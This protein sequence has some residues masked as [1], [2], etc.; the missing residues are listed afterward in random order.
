MT[1]QNHNEEGCS[2]ANL[3]PVFDVA[4]HWNDEVRKRIRWIPRGQTQVIQ[5]TKTHGGF[6]LQTPGAPQWSFAV[7]PTLPVGDPDRAHRVLLRPGQC[8][9]YAQF[10]PDQ[11]ALFL[12]CLSEN[13]ID[14]N[15]PV[16][17]CARLLAATYEWRLFV[18]RITPQKVLHDILAILDALDRSRSVSL[19]RHLAWCAYF[20][21]SQTHLIVL[22]ELISEGCRMIDGAI[23]RLILADLSVAKQ[24]VRPEIGLVIE[25]MFGTGYDRNWANLDFQKRFKK[26]FEVLYP[27]GLDLQSPPQWA[28]PEYKVLCQELKHQGRCFVTVQDFIQNSSLIAQIKAVS[29]P[30]ASGPQINDMELNRVREETRRVDDLL[31]SRPELESEAALIPVPTEIPKQPNP[32]NLPLILE[33]IERTQWAEADFKQ[34][35]R[36]HG[37]MPHALSETINTWALVNFGETLLGGNGPVVVSQ[38]TAELIKKAYVQNK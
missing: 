9:G 15:A 10:N 19:L 3:V 22:E 12:A 35:A 8:M 26:R 37:T 14:E 33:L 27:S 1:A 29:L 24:P 28:Q 31:S 4:A 6:Y 11:R 38:Q 36:K 17:I 20:C 34:F 16:E 32:Q 21:G 7:D 5:G 25:H 2:R 23:I 30:L 13:E 18:D